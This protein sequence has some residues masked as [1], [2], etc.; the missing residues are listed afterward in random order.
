M[1][2]VPGVILAQVPISSMMDDQAQEL[3]DQIYKSIK[4]VHAN[5]VIKGLPYLRKSIWRMEEQKVVCT[6][7]SGSRILDG[8][9]TGSASHF[10]GEISSLYH[11]FNAALNGDLFE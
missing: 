9:D 10:R 7:F 2:Y 6:D 8:N 5:G 3:W 4:A 1:E 11:Q